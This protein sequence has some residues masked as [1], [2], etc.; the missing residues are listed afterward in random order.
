MAPGTR[1]KFDAPM[2]EPEVFRKQ[3][4]CIEESN[5]E[6]W[7]CLDFSALPVVIWRSNSNSV[8]GELCPPCPLSLRPWALSHV[9][10]LATTYVKT[11]GSFCLAGNFLY[12]TLLLTKTV[13]RKSSIGGLCD[14]AGGLD[15]KNW[16]K[17]HWFIVFQI[18][19]W[20]AKPT[21]APR[22]DGTF[23]Y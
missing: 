7:H 22:G 19:I 6:L 5:C 3:I 20:G 13:A 4:H 2:F 23:T 18:S 17:F 14:C 16:Q 11:F 1:S 10:N 21:K 12:Q 15:I 9:M 8:P